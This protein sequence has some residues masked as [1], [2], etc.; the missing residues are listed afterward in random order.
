MSSGRRE[1]ER[2]LASGAGRPGGDENPG[3]TAFATAGCGG[4]HEFAPAG[5]DAQVGPSLDAVDPGGAPLEDY[6]RESI[7]DP[8]ANVVSGY[9]PDVMPTTYD[10][11]LTD[12]QLDALVQY[13]AEGQKP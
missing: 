13:L 7:V 8:N 2:F 11:S 6:L 4:C 1:Y 5:T 10:S 9:Q 3:E 12:E